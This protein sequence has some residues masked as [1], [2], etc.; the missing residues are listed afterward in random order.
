MCRPLSYYLTRALLY[1]TVLVMVVWTLAPVT[2]L[3]ISSIS[4]HAEL[5]STPIHWVPEHPTGENFSSMFD[6]RQ[7]T[8][9]RFLA[10][11]R[12]SMFIAGSVTLF[13]LVVGTLAAYAL[14]RLPFRGRNGLIM[15]LLAVRMLPVIALVIPFFVLII[16]LEYIVPIF[17]DRWWT[18]AILYNAF[19][20]GFVVWIMRGYFLTIPVELE[21]AAR[22]DGCTR[23]AALRLVVLPLAAPGLVATGILAFLLAWDEFLL[24][25]IFSKTTNA[26]T[27]PLYITQLGSQYITAYESIAAA[28]VMAALPP[29]LLALL[30]QRWIVS[31]LTAGGVKG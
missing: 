9:R 17:Y 16:R 4:T 1:F 6:P 3:F 28:G 10:A 26:L 8:G 30:F 23:L 5:L 18:L 24:A 2:W 15:G 27:L 20:L 7:D 21:E 22:I 25:L 19:I 14:A 13:S 11:F 31:G 12:N 29:V